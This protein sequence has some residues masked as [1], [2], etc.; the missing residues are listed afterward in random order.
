[1]QEKKVHKG[2]TVVN[3]IYRPH[4][5]PMEDPLYRFQLQAVSTLRLLQRDT[6]A[7]TLCDDQRTLLV[8][9]ELRIFVF[10]RSRI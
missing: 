1:M 7:H 3:P 2:G 6:K 9:V 8:T 10:R 5:P 4:L